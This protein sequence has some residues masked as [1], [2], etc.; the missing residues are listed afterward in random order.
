MTNWEYQLGSPALAAQFLAK[1]A[2]MCCH[3][4]ADCKDCP[5]IETDDVDCHDYRELREWL[6]SEMD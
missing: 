2:R 1:L 4:D 3:S 6:E 5:L